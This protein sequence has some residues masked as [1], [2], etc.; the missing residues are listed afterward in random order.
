MFT[1]AQRLKLFWLEIITLYQQKSKSSI[2]G[3][4]RQYGITIVF[5]KKQ[6]L[7]A[8]KYCIVYIFEN[9]VRSF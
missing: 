8:I 2:C 6:E 5:E 9:L 4:R 7:I 3:K 1:E